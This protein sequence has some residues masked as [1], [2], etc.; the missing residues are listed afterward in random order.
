MQLYNLIR[1]NQIKANQTPDQTYWQIKCS[2][3]VSWL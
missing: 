3:C 2:L 1:Q